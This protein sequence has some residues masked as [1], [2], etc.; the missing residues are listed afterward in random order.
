[1]DKEKS[2]RDSK[3]DAADRDESG[4]SFGANFCSEKVS[5]G[6]DFYYDK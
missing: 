6:A 2:R 5:D 3:I 4:R 1:M